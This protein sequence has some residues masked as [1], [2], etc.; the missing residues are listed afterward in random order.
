MD[1]MNYLNFDYVKIARSIDFTRKHDIIKM[2]K[3]GKPLKSVCE[4]V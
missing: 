4:K 3:V 2:D 1:K